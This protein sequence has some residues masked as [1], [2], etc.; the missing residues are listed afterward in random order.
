[1]TMLNDIFL[2]WTILSTPLVLRCTLSCHTNALRTT[3]GV[4]SLPTPNARAGL[5][6]IGNYGSSQ[7]T[8]PE[9]N[10]FFQP[11]LFFGC[12]TQ[13]LKTGGVQIGANDFID[14]NANGS[15]RRPRTFQRHADATLCKV[16]HT[17]KDVVTSDAGSP[18][19]VIVTPM[20]FA[21]PA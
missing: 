18:S 3:T 14:T 13:V 5:Q 20:P 9:L 6:D 19:Y 8:P 7:R 10:A 15:G 11:R 2:S 16:M 4:P 1:M 17:T 21:L 12:L